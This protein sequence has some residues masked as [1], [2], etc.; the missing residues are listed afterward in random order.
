MEEEKPASINPFRSTALV[1][2]LTVTAA[3]FL[4]MVFVTGPAF[5]EAAG[6]ALPDGRIGGYTPAD[7]LDMH[8]GAKAN[9]EAA[10]IANHTTG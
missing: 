8:A 9:R 6:V 3:L 5:K 4:Y 2:L 7:V 10:D 1:A